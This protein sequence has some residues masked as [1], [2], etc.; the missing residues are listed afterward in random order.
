MAAQ[1]GPGQNSVSWRSILHTSMNPE[2]PTPILPHH[3]TLWD[4]ASGEVGPSQ[5]LTPVTQASAD[6]QTLVLTTALG[7]SVV[8]KMSSSPGSEPSQGTRPDQQ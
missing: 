6:E 1:Q 2:V 8:H 3:W 4:D 5:G 7:T